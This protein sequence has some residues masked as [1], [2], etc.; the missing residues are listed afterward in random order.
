MADIE[1]AFNVEQGIS[2]N[3]EVGIFHGAHDPIAAGEIAP[4]G[5]LYLRTNGQLY[6]KIGVGDQEWIANGG[7][8]GGGVTDHGMLTGLADDDHPQYLNQTRGDARY[9]QLLHDH[10]HASLTG[11]TSDDHPQYFNV[12]RGDARY[13]LI[14]H[15][16]DFNSLTD[17]TIATPANGD[18]VMFNSA[19]GQWE[20]VPLVGNQIMGGVIKIAHSATIPAISGT[21]GIP[22]DN[23]PPLITEGTE[24]WTYTMTPS[25]SG[26]NVVI[27]TTGTVEVAASNK[28]V[29]LAFFRNSTCIGVSITNLNASSRPQFISAI[30]KD[31]SIS[32]APVTY[33]CRV[34]VAGS[35]STWYF[36]REGTSYFNG[37]LEKN[38]YI[39]LEY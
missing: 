8:S 16:H 17:A 28:Q 14:T 39:L 18:I 22:Y 20:N 29:L 36:N 7:G 19:T 37:L 31:N 21:A 25:Y 5:S 24:I 12:T 23:T 9:S 6:S 33:S 38:S 11:L 10:S 13:S 15:T 32:T 35:T 27:F 2:L 3:D 1:H 34:G 26:S 30:I 4:V